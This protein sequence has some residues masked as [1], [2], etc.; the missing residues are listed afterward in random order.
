MI[1]ATHISRHFGRFEAL[2]EIS[3][4]VPRGEI[5]GIM[6]ANGAGKSTLFNILVTLDDIFGG[7]LRILGQDA[8]TDQV[9][10]RQKIGYVPGKF[11]LYG[12]LTVSENLSFFASVYGC[13][14]DS[15]YR[16][17]SSLWKSLEPFSRLQARYLSGGMK[18]KLSVCCALVHSPEILFLDEPTTGI[19]PLSRH[20][21]WQELNHLKAGGTTIL[22]S[23]H[24]LEEAFLTD[25]ILLLHNGT[26]LAL[27]TPGKM[28]S[29]YKNKL[30]SI[31]G[32]PAH[33]L[34]QIL[35][36]MPQA[37]ACYVYG[38]TLHMAF[39]K[40]SPPDLLLQYCTRAGLDRVD[41][42]PADPDMEDVFM[43]ILTTHSPD[44]ASLP[45]TNSIP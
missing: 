15:V 13:R 8:R 12:D 11:S 4:F 36:S 30:V 16:N 40:E 45:E 28:I 27:D 17:C 14:A 3:F 42:Q 37:K 32:Y 18:Q 23:T 22:V 44:P 25:R 10:I 21:L 5:L 34:Y 39:P 31:S 41:I 24:Y 35:R 26:Q 2:K 20:E 6:G 19:D 29:E 1:E 9:S 7:E 33:A 38:Q 43:E